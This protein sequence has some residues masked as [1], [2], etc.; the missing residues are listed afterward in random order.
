M[1]LL[2][3]KEQVDNACERAKDYK[4]E[5]TDIPVCLQIDN[6]NG[7]SFVASKDIEL[8]YDNN[9]QASGCVIQAWE[10]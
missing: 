2:E 3:L 1:D 5:L 6:T 8:H 9:C 4:V 10:D 7:N